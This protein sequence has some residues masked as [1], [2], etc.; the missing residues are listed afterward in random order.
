MDSLMHA[1]QTSK[2]QQH[3][4]PSATAIHNND[5]DDDINPLGLLAEPVSKLSAQQ[6]GPSRAMIVNIQ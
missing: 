4:Q 1:T 6:V 5:D 3:D 2:Q